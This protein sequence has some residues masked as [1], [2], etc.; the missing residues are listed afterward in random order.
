MNN[1][2]IRIG[3]LEAKYTIGLEKLLTVLTPDVNNPAITD[4]DINIYLMMLK[5]GN[6]EY[7]KPDNIVKNKYIFKKLADCY[8][9]VK[10]SKLQRYVN[11]GINNR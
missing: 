10:P 9:R 6:V 11:S 4:N 7:E 3:E 5:Q 1:N 8:K 2:N